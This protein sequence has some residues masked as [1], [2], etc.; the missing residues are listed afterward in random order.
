MAIAW[1]ALEVETDTYCITHYYTYPCVYMFYVIDESSDIL[2]E[3]V[4]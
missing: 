2:D 4:S 3:P 1:E